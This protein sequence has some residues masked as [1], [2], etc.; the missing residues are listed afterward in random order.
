MARR[1]HGLFHRRECEPL[2]FAFF[3]FALR[4]PLA[5]FSRVAASLLGGYA[6]AWGFTTLSIALALRAGLPFGE[7]RTLAQLL[8]FLVFLGAFLWAFS[9]PRQLRLWLVL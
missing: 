9:T 2:S 7:A 8:A 5:L 1:P 4:P 3:M 6:F